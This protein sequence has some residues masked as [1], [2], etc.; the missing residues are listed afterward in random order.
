MDR[1]DTVIV[2]A[3]AV[4]LAVASRLGSRGGET[5]VIERHPG[6]G[7]ET[8]SHNSEVIH[9]GLY[10]PTGSLKAR[11]CVR[12]K[13]LLYEF[14]DSHKVAFKQL[15]K[16][17]IAA[18]ES[19]VG[20]LE[21]LAARARANGVEDLRLIDR[22]EL[23]KMEPAVRGIAALHSPSTGIMDSHSLMKRME[24]MA[25]DSGVVFAYGCELAAIEPGS[26]GY[27]L[28][29]RD[30]DGTHTQLFARTVINCAGLACEEVARMAG[31]DT[32]AAGYGLYYC[33]GEYFRL[34]AGKAGSITHLI[35]P[36][37]T[38]ISLGTHIVID[39]EG[40][41]KLGPSAFFV[42]E[43]DYEVDPSH[44][45]EFYTAARKLLPSI[46][47]GDLSPDMAGIRPKIQGPGEPAKDFVIA[48]EAGR[49]LPGLINLVGI[50]S[51]GL[52]AC[53]AIAEHVEALLPSS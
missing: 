13:H 38:E 37:P 25:I 49:G 41:L 5:V 40:G 3:G 45:G 23:K 24:S 8:S 33:K 39:M 46:E 20:P 35:Y 6:F 12:G 30:A 14:C 26:G 48:H 42:E 50:E 43:I 10:Y 9:A 1:V 53:L 47:E 51:P 29:V 36:T 7:W 27:G 34:S 44:A 31:I 21:S 19:E 15:G 11:L 22:Q 52:T 17:V 32:T 18:D 4:G 28:K 16:L 2:G